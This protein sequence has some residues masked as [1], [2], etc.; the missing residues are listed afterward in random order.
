[1]GEDV[2]RKTPL[3]EESARL[4][5]RMVEFAGW[6]MPQ[7][8]RSIIEEV[9]ALR[10]GVALFDISHMGLIEIFS[11][12]GEALSFTSRMVCSRIDALKDGSARYTALLNERGGFVDDLI[13]YRLSSRRIMLCVNAANKDKV[14]GWLAAHAPSDKSIRIV[15]K[16]YHFGAIALQGP[17]AADTLARLIGAAPVDKLKPFDFITT[18]VNSTDAFIARLGYTGEDGFELICSWGS[19]PM[20]WGELMKKGAANKIAPAG[21]GARDLARLEMK[22]P[23]YGAEIDQDINPYEANLGW[24]VA[25]EKEGGFIGREALAKIK[26]DQAPGRALVGL[27]FDGRSLPRAG[28]SIYHKGIVVGSVVSGGFSP[29]IRA[30]IA[31]GFVRADLAG[32]G[33]MA[34]VESR[35]KKIDASIHLDKAFIPTPRPSARRKESERSNQ[36]T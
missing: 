13:V 32:A 9:E 10:S 11:A 34:Q 16:T 7:R 5:A 6:L 2:A 33:R 17:L 20:L 8:Y 24:L 3:S 28:A 35:D 23:L 22:Y 15:D 18:S 12:D 4:G 19:T 27:K 31:L 36:E 25:L 26:A 14:L 29:T 21:L 1:M 30:P